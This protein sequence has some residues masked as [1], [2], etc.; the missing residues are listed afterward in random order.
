MCNA[1]Y[2]S[3]GVRLY[4]FV[5]FVLFKKNHTYEKAKASKNLCNDNK[6]KYLRHLMLKAA[7]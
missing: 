5:Y 1:S 3:M 7:M 4:T 6:M 2:I